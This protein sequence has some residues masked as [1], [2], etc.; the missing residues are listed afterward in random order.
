MSRA[1]I[2]VIICIIPFMICELYWGYN[3]ISCQDKHNKL[4]GV[5]IGSWL[6]VDG[7]IMLAQSVIILLLACMLDLLVCCLPFLTVLKYFVFCWTCTG[8]ALYWG[9]GESGLEAT[10]ACGKQLQGYL[11]TR[12]ALGLMNGLDILFNPTNNPVLS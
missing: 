2:W 11:N 6:L 1:F 10:H 3:D 7:F 4:V 9:D 8:C 5:S 12:L